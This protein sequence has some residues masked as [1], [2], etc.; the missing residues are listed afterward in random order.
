MRGD[1][2]ITTIE[3][4]P[5]HCREPASHDRFA[6]PASAADPPDMAQPGYQSLVIS[7]MRL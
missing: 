7:G 2:V 3:M 6:G 4:K 1:R 5:M